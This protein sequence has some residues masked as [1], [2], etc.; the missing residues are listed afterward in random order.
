L[1]DL[2]LYFGLFISPFIL[3]FAVSVFYLN[4]GKLIAGDEPPAET[5]RDLSLPDGFDRLKGREA[6]DRATAILPQLR[7]SGEIGYLRYVA[8]DR[9]LIFPVSKAGA[10]A[11]VDVDLDART[12]TVK[13]R[14][15]NL[16]ESLSYLHK[17]P[18]PHNVAI[19]GNWIGIGIWRLFADATIY[20]VLF[21]SLSGV[22]LWWAIK[23]ER[24]IGAV[25]LASG[26]FTFVGLVYAV[27]R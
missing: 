9:H 23:A 24:R 4:H 5:Y 14:S 25:L 1:R 8:R 15:M 13:R 20:L 7:I 6:V 21:I 17:M 16:W 19:R 12:A 18:G 10:E 2:H 22:Y 27:I 11:T 3:L 26:A